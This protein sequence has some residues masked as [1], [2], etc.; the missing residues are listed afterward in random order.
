MIANYTN[1][2]ANER[3]FL[4]WLRTD[5]AVT[6]FGFFLAKRNVFFDAVA[7]PRQSSCPWRCEIDRDRISRMP[8]SYAKPVHSAVVSITA[9]MF[10][11]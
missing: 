7:G 2:A 8:Q 9:T 4:A 11:V 10:C 1:H 3:T 5:L 6:A